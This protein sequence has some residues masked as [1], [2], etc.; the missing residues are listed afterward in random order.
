VFCSQPRRGPGARHFWFLDPDPPDPWNRKG[1]HRGFTLIELIIVIAIML[2]L[3]AIAIPQFLA[4][5]DVARVTKAVADIHTMES[6]IMAYQVT[7]GGLPH[8]LADIGRGGFPD[9]WGAPYQYLNIADDPLLSRVRLDRFLQPL[10]SDYDLF[11][12]GK[13][14]LSVPATTASV[15][16]DDVIRANDGAYVGLASQY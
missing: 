13:D 11:S 10:N 8:T 14:G 5:R 16:A 15:S 7:T 2:T 3:A 12:K 9:P 4:A 6:D 1:R